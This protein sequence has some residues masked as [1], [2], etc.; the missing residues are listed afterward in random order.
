MFSATALAPSIQRGN[1]RWGLMLQLLP[2]IPVCV[3]MGY[4]LYIRPSSMGLLAMSASFAP[5]VMAPNL[6][7]AT[8]AVLL[9]RSFGPGAAPPVAPSCAEHSPS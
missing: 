2:I 1:L 3:V 6:T 7:N 9:T 8:A 5:T 4:V